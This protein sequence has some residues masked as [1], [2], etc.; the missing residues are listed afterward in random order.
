MVWLQ[1]L[2]TLYTPLADYSIAHHSRNQFVDPHPAHGMQRTDRWPHN[3]AWRFR[4]RPPLSP[5]GLVLVGGRERHDGLSCI[6]RDGGYAAVAVAQRPWA[7][8]TARVCRHISRSPANEDEEKV[9]RRYFLA[10]FT[11]ILQSSSH[12]FELSVHFESTSSAFCIAPTHQC[13]KVS[14]SQRPAA[15]LFEIIRSVLHVNVTG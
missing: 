12:P 13:I 10:Q 5:S 11:I 1:I 6:C 2:Y 9:P 14:L 3:S 4:C 15:R 8:S 7:V